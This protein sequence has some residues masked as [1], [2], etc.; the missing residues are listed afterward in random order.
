LQQPRTFPVVLAG[1]A[2]FLDLYAPQ[3]LLP[4]L[5]RV[6]GASSFA[7]S[8]TITS[9]TIAVAVS[10]PLAGR[11]ADRVGLRRVI[12]ASA[13][14]LSV[15]TALVATSQTLGELVAWRLLQGAITPG[16][17]GVALAY[18]LEEW[19]ADRVGRAT[20]AYV[21][22]TVLGGFVGR[23]TTGFFASHYTWQSGFAVLA[24]ANLAT[25][26]LLAA[27]L[28]PERRHIRR[29]HASRE[30]R[31]SALLR[32][33]PLVAT[34]A[35]GF[36]VLCAQ[37]A[38]FTYITFPLAAAPFNLSPATLG[39]LFSVY[40]VGAVATPLSGRWIDVYGHRAVL[41]LAVGLGAAGALMTLT[42]LLPV[43]VCGLSMFATAIFIAQA[44]ASSHVGVHANEGRGLAIGLYATCYYVGGTVGGALPA[45]LWERGGWPACV[46]F[47]ICVQAAM[48]ATA[49]LFWGGRPGHDRDQFV[50]GSGIVSVA[51]GG[52]GMPSS[53]RSS[54]PSITST[55]SRRRVTA[56]S[57]SR[58]SVRIRRAVS[59]A[60]VRIRLISASIFFAVS[61]P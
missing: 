16:V 32:R 41:T 43:V 9:A 21:G 22:G 18:I 13:F 19:P 25:A 2:A 40:L 34:Y 33:P 4:T 3:P 39:F 59:C 47:I 56:S 6:F 37:L 44:S 27:T 11:L 35:V 52:G 31:V 14:A 12:V 61:S 30:A 1:F 50:A 8:L 28:R 36:C 5:A 54:S 53:L 45:P 29:A 60:S 46:A 15:A 10:A 38:M 58:F 42:P 51:G 55:T 20:G 23:A 24:A 7:V 48:L 17:F 49:W 57:L 26:I